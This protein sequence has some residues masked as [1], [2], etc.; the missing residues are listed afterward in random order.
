ML[1]PVITITH[2]TVESLPL[3]YSIAGAHFGFYDLKQNL[4]SG[5]GRP[6][7]FIWELYAEMEEENKGLL[8]LSRPL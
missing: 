2:S 8:L 7:S 1:F 3:E 6:K 4:F 5:F